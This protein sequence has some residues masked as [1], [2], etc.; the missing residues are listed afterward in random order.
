MLNS[1]MCAFMLRA[2]LPAD[3][4]Y[5]TDPDWEERVQ[6]CFEVHF[7]AVQQDI[8]PIAA[9]AVAWRESNWTAAPENRW[10]CI[11]PMQIKWRYWCQNEDDVWSLTR[12]DGYLE[13][14]D[15]VDRGV[16]ALRYYINREPTLRRAFCS[17]AAGSCS[18]RKA[19]NDR[20]TRLALRTY[21]LLQRRRAKFEEML[22]DIR[23]LVPDFL[24]L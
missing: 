23:S 17:Y 16:F 15:L 6:V 9:L 18:T 3:M 12:A 8:D 22:E 19:R 24:P 2:L 14:C 10:G 13:T 21:R 1:L 5:E 7:S 20:Y 4:N 11:G